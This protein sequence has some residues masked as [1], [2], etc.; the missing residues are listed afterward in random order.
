M[1]TNEAYVGCIALTVSQ[2]E[3]KWDHARSLKCCLSG[4]LCGFTLPPGSLH[5]PY[6]VPTGKCV[7]PYTPISDRFWRNRRM[8]GCRRFAELLV[9]FLILSDSLD[10]FEFWPGWRKNVR[11]NKVSIATPEKKYAQWAFSFS[12]KKETLTLCH[13][14]WGQMQTSFHLRWE[15]SEKTKYRTR[16]IIIEC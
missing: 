8:L 2:V 11:S 10:L 4:G 12:K 7:T 9:P 1:G 16:Q 6:G 14:F 15:N 3:Q 5:P 13:V